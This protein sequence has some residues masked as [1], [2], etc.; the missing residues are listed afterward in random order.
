MREPM[1]YTDLARYLTERFEL[2]TPLSRHQ[3]YNWDRRQTRNARGEMF[4]GPAELRRDK[5]AKLRPRR[6]FSPE[7]AGSWFA[8]GPSP[9]GRQ[10]EAGW[11]E[12][13]RARE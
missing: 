10:P 13:A 4:P 9:A 11:Q 6:L 3:V 1:G 12:P 8:A 5:A 2:D 7:E